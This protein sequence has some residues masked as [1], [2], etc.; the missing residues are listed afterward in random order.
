MI[1]VVKP[2]LQ[3]H[4]LKHIHLK[5]TLEYLAND[6][7]L[8]WADLVVF[9][10][11]TEPQYAHLL[12]ALK[13]RNIPFTY[14][15]DD[16]FFELPLNLEIGRYH[17]KPQRLAMVRCYLRSASLTRVYSQPL[18]ERALTL[19]QHA[20][21][22]FAPI[23]LSLISPPRVNLNS[24]TVKIVYATSRISDELA[25]MFIPALTR[26]LIRYKGQVE[27]HF[28]GSMPPELRG[29]HG[30]YQHSLTRSYD[31]FLRRF[32]KAGFDIGLAPLPNDIFHRSKTNNKFREYG[33]CRI[34]GI[35]SN[36]DV[37]SSCVTDAETGL[38]IPNET[39][40]WYQAMGRLI[41][42]RHLREKIK[43]QARDYVSEH[44]SQE[45]FEKV[46]LGQIQALLT[47]RALKS[48]SA[49]KTGGVTQ[50][51]SYL[52]SKSL[53]FIRHL[54]MEGISVTFRLLRLQLFGF[55]MVLKLRLQT[56]RTLT[57]L[58]RKQTH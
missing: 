41:E 35:Y 40:A 9:C 56:S 29:F 54:R 4:R 32:S 26:I 16:N 37:Y 53:S 47:G 28:W 6:Q 50:T 42:D 7:S 33:A 48:T 24:E 25:A 43:R 57:I 34:A 5:I 31:Q 2:F 39:E 51:L 19:S 14:D 17:R 15:L 18:L 21:K 44:Y 36:V 30:V 11:N 52:A 13:K 49:G 3:L 55:W 38:L 27:S 23:D 8:N 46:W 20:E 10:R 22:L 1:L 45:L 58:N 12:N